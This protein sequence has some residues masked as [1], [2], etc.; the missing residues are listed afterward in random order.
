MKKFAV[1]DFRAWRIAHN[2]TQDQAAKLIGLTVHTI[3]AW[4]QGARELPM[5]IGLLIERLRPED[6]PKQAGTSGNRPIGINTKIKR[7]HSTDR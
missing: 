6:Y 3:R 1:S 2:L 4:E 7:L 5:H